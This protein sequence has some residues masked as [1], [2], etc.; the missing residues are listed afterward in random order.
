MT[1]EELREACEMAGLERLVSGTNPYYTDGTEYCWHEKN[2]AL[3]A[4]VASLLVE[5]VRDR[6]KGWFYYTALMCEVDALAT[7]AR[8]IASLSS[9]E[10]RIRA[11]ME[12]LRK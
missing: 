11:A 7:E 12:V 9:D 5:K 6:G 3:P 2:P 4:Y 8:D 1:H 10:Q